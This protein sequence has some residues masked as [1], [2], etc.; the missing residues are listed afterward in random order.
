MSG[1][2]CSFNQN[3]GC[4]HPPYS[5]D[6]FSFR[7]SPS[8]SY[9]SKN[10]FCFYDQL[11]PP[12][13]SDAACKNEP[14]SRTCVAP[15]LSLPSEACGLLSYAESKI[16]TGLAGRE[17][18]LLGGVLLSCDAGKVPCKHLLPRAEILCRSLGLPPEAKPSTPPSE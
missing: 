13:G 16:S 2:C 10:D 9:F 7:A 8:L 11:K 17:S 4:R 14:Q 15:N 1:P 18:G 5:L 3:L 6:I 12:V